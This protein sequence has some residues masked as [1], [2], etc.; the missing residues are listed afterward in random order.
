[1][2]SPPGVLFA[3]TKIKVLPRLYAPSTTRVPI[4]LLD[5]LCHISLPGASTV[6]SW[7]CPIKVKAAVRDC[8]SRTALACALLAIFYPKERLQGHRL[9][10]LDQDII[11]AITGMY[12]SPQAG[13]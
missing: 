11:E 1:M 5:G 7:C 4:E 3:W 6:M 8:S 9:H 2:A 13:R 12:I 10:E